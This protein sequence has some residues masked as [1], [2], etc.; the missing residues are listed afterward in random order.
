MF[1]FLIFLL[2]ILLV[3]LVGGA[4]MIVSFFT[5]APYVGT[6]RRALADI[7]RL[8]GLHA[9]QTLVDLGS[10]D[11]RVMLAAMRVGVRAVGYELNPVLCA[12]TWLRMRLLGRER[13][14]LGRVV[15]R[16]FWHADLSDADA[17]TVYCMPHIMDRLR[18]KIQAECRTGT[19][20]VSFAFTFPNWELA[21]REG[22]VRVYVV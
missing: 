6:S 14:Q 18:R 22:R 17:V 4:F 13:A 15:C 8:S 20:V 1:I 2:A 5:G 12:I 16:N 19:R 7:I 21:A 9:G 11:G 3:L 10:G